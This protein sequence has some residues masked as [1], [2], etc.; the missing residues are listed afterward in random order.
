MTYVLLPIPKA[1]SFGTCPGLDV[2]DVVASHE[3]HLEVLF[4]LHLG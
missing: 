1:K 4:E 2:V 3:E